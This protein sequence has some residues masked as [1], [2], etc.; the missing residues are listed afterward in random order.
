MS[1]NRF[2]KVVTVLLVLITLGIGGVL[3]YKMITNGDT[4][5]ILETSVDSADSQKTDNESILP[6]ESIEDKIDSATT[7]LKATI[8]SVIKETG[9]IPN[10][11]FQD[12]FKSLKN[13][14][15]LFT[16]ISP[17]WYELNENGS[18]KS[19]KPYNMTEFLSYCREKNIRVIP[20]IAMFDWK[21]FSKV[22]NNKDAFDRHIKSIINEID[23]Y[24]YDGIDIDYEST[25]LAD[26]ELF[27]QFLS[28][29]SA[30]LK[31]R[32][33]IFSFAVLSQW[34]DNVIYPSL[35]E[36]RRV[37]E[38]S[39]MNQYIDEFRIMTY[40]YTGQSSPIPGPIAPINWVEKVIQYA[41][42]QIP[43]EKI[44]IGIHLYSFEW[45]NKEYDPNFDTL[46][47]VPSSTRASSYTYSTI[48]KKLNIKGATNKYY[49]EIA[50]SVLTYPCSGGK[51]TLVYQSPEGIAARRLLVSEYGL[52]GVAYWR[53]GED[54]NLI[55]KK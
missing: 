4:S 55:E 20:S 9:W 33:K 45:K 22:L 29:L 12:G 7:S 37:Q 5:E 54:G 21:L 10:W 51:C 39:R 14:H 23:K 43:R 47:V 48:L 38:W 17:V 25:Q 26:K 8:P 35:K 6:N 13:N 30:K 19:L 34:G 31:S 44:W 32:N 53:I 36:T 15:E 28:E 50:E 46:E 27:F 24:N 1:R 16:S 52:A 3:V 11:D 49:P 41:V 18:L 42:T 40:D 2:G